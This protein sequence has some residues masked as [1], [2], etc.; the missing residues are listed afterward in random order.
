[1]EE[2][3]MGERKIYIVLTD[4]GTVFT[5]LIK[6]YTKSP[7]NHVSVAF[8]KQLKEIYS[9]GRKNPHNPFFA[10]FVRENIE[11]RLFQRAACQIYGMAV[12][13][14]EYNQLV[15]YIEQLK[16]NHKKYKYNLIGLFGIMFDIE[17]HRKYA[18]FCSQFI[19]T[20]FFKCGIPLTEKSPNLTTPDDIR[21]SNKLC[22]EYEGKLS[23]YLFSRNIRLSGT[24]N[25]LVSFAG[26][27][28]GLG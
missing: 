16:K 19:A 2:Q 9:F 12:T 3:Q 26:E 15:G 5:R 11:S 10:G 27:E 7:Y 1:M 8:D 28:A 25:K 23:A 14:S 6:L 13:E 20:L 4:T 18:Y 17:I 24:R 21:K 22:L